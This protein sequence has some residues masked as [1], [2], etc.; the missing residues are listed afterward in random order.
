MRRAKDAAEQLRQELAASEAAREEEKKQATEALRMAREK[1]DKQAH[2][3]QRLAGENAAY[4]RQMIE[5]QGVLDG[6]ESYLETVSQNGQNDT[7]DAILDLVGKSQSTHRA[8]II[9]RAQAAL[10][11]AKKSKKLIGA[12]KGVLA[13]DA[14]TARFPR[15]HSHAASRLP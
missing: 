3:N 7:V 8:R 1:G 11:T 9:K 6:V 12:L 15:L 4:K 5:L 10:Q 13:R 2:E 14:L